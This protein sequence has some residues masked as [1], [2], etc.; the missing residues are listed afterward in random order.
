MSAATIVGSL[1]GKALAIL[2]QATLPN[3]NKMLDN[4]LGLELEV[5][6]TNI[7]AFKDLR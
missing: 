7:L 4:N 1:G 6:L 5:D 3:N 2:K